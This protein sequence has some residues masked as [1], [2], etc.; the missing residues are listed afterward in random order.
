MERTHRLLRDPNALTFDRSQMAPTRKSEFVDDGSVPLF[1]SEPDP[2][3]FASPNPIGPTTNLTRIAVVGLA[4]LTFAII[5]AAVSYSDITRVIVD[6]ARSAASGAITD[7]A[8]KQAASSKLDS[9][10]SVNEVG[11]ATVARGEATASTDHTAPQGPTKAEAKGNERAA[12]SKALDAETLLSL[13]TRAKRLLAVG[14]VVPARLLLE[15]AAGAQDATAAFL[16]A[17]TYDP[18]VLGARDTR[19]ITPDPAAA[20]DWYRKAASLGSADAQQRLTKLQN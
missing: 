1:L 17:R 8:A 5:L 20:R 2:P 13:V 10:N 4:G 9:E 14:D 16:L 3:H 19:S 12:P 6:K 15:R 18:D 11:P 7:Q